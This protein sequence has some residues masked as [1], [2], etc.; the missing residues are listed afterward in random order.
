MNITSNIS[1]KIGYNMRRGTAL[2]EPHKSI[3][4]EIGL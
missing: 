1:H 3:L 4:C 2:L